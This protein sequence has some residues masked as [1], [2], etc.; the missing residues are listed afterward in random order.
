MCAI[1]SVRFGIL[2]PL[3]VWRDDGEV[4]VGGQRGRLLLALLLALVLV[5]AGRVVPP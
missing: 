2:G 4:D 1:V 5:E 3:E